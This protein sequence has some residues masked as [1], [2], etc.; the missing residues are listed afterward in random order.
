M[1]NEMINTGSERIIVSERRKNK[2]GEKEVN[3]YYG[4]K[5]HYKFI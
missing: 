2:D 5:W 1:T 4:N 3:S